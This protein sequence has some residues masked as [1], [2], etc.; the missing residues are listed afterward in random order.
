MMSDD[1]GK[2]QPLKKQ[3]SVKLGTDSMGVSQ[4]T[5]S[6]TTGRK[7]KPSPLV[8]TCDGDPNPLVENEASHDP[9]KGQIALSKLSPYVSSW[10]QVPKASSEKKVASTLSPYVSTWDQQPPNFVSENKMAQKSIRSNKTLPVESKPDDFYAQDDNDADAP[11]AAAGGSASHVLEGENL[12]TSLESAASSSA[13][14]PKE[15]SDPSEEGELEMADSD[16]KE[17]CAAGLQIKN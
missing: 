8:P 16:A 10:N 6:T 11:K 2:L 3:R 1:D 4:G 7:I 15:E 12:P 13:S 9:H 5:K 14:F 17:S